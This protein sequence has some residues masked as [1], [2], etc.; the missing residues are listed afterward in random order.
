MLPFSLI[1]FIFSGE[2]WQAAVH[3]VA[4]SRTRLSDFTFT[5]HFHALEKAMALHSSI[6]AWR[7]PG[8]VEP[9]G[10][11]SMGLHRVRHDWSDTAAAAAVGNMCLDVWKKANTSGKKSQAKHR[12]QSRTSFKR[13]CGNWRAELEDNPREVSRKRWYPEFWVTTLD[14]RNSFLRGKTPWMEVQESKKEA[15]WQTGKN[16]YGKKDY[17]NI[18]ASQGRSYNCSRTKHQRMKVWPDCFNKQT[19][20]KGS[21]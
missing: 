17:S 20:W 10:L 5:F 11:P 16:D 4:K 2:A 19:R 8:M 6:F 7:I 9:G 21:Y 12:S 14:F 13:R 3:G 15:W 18:L 1:I